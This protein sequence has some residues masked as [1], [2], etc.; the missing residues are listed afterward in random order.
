[1]PPITAAAAGLA[2]D[3]A[4]AK[5]QR[6]CI[7]LEHNIPPSDSEDND[8]FVPPPL[9]PLRPRVR[10]QGESD[11]EACAAELQ[12]LDQADR[13]GHVCTH[14]QQVDQRDN[15]EPE[16][17]VGN[18]TARRARIQ[19]PKLG[20]IQDYMGQLDICLDIFSDAVVTLCSVADDSI[21][22][23][24]YQDHLVVWTEHCENLKDRASEVI[25]VLKA[26]QFAARIPVTTQ[27]VGLWS[28][29]KEMH[30]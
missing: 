13:A 11:C 7:R 22:K 9:R 19:Q 14:N 24:A 27:T 16:V 30:G 21:D 12:E 3:K 28:R 5:L 1:M 8:Q 10:L 4:I 18:M 6:A 23:H 2:Y 26:A 20:V 29:L 25:E 15:V 17:S